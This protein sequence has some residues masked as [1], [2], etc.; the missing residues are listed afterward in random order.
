MQGGS[1]SAEDLCCDPI[2]TTVPGATGAAGAAGADGTDG[3]NAF[4][5]LDG[6][7]T[8]PAE[9]ANV[10]TVVD[11]NT[12]M[13]L[14]QTLFIQ[15]AGYM[16]VA[17]LNVN[18]V[19]VTLTNLEDAATSTYPDNAAPATA[20][21]NDSKVS[22]SGVTGPAG[23]AAASP[24]PVNATYITQT[25][26]ATLTNEQPLSALATGILRSTTGTGVV[27]IAADGTDYLSPTTGLE[28]ADIGVTVQA[29]DATLTSIA[30]LGTAAD[31]IA[32]T[33]GVD[34][35]AETPLTAAGRSVIDDATVTAM[36]TTLG[37]QRTPQD[38]LI[39]Q[40]QL[41]AGTNAGD[42]DPAAGWAT[43]P[44][45]TEVADTGGLGSIAANTITL[46]TGVYRVHWHMHGYQVDRFQSRLF[47]VTTAAIIGYG[48]NAKSA[49]ADTCM[50]T[51][52]G[53]AR[54]TITAA[55]EDIR[56]QAQCETL[57]AGDGFGIANA[58]GGVQC[59]AGIWLEKEVG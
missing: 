47:N 37:V 57:N 38:I 22:P 9:L 28:P 3:V 31:R 48:S 16:R 12:W 29:F 55:T 44:L 54:I 11:D 59:Y 21:P 20:I 4:T 41:A 53:E 30:L 26:N 17:A 35:W 27:S 13:A 56:I 5:L 33:T 45:N 43:V 40:H 42:F 18:G 46:A 2:V 14:G 25:P 10:V 8:M 51:S 34:T 39:Y 1:C 15:V 19:G 32:Y 36:R 52:E 6:G 58:F 7:F 50:S 49:A 24:A 23:A